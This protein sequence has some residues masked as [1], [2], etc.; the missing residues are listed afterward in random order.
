M[1]LPNTLAYQTVSP[2]H[3]GSRMEVSVQEKKAER[4][5]SNTGTP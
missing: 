4:W 1:A 3:W 5:V 2:Q